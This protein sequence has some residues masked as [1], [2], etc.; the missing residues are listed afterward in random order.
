MQNQLSLFDENVRILENQEIRTHKQ[1]NNNVAYDVGV[2]IGGARKDQAALRK[3]FEENRDL[4]NLSLL[5][6]VSPV[7]AS[8]VVTRKEL[9]KDFSLSIE[10]EKGTSPQAAKIKDLVI[11][12]IQSIPSDS[13]ESREEFVKAALNYQML[14]ENI[15]TIDEFI[16]FIYEIR[17]KLTAD[18]MSMFNVKG[19]LRV[20]KE[21]LEKTPAPSALHRQYTKELK[22]YNAILDEGSIPDRVKLTALGPNFVKFFLSAKS[23]NTSLRN[24]KRDIQ[25]WDHLTIKSRKK[26]T[27]N[28]PLWERELPITPVI[29]AGYAYKIN[30]PT[31]LMELFSFRGVE[32]GHYM[33]D[34]R[35]ADHINNCASAFMD[36]SNVLNMNHNFSISLNGT[37]SMAF[38]SRGRGKA[39]GHYEP[40]AKVINL[41]KNRGLLG[42]A[43]HEWFHALDNW[44]F[45]MSHNYKNGQIGFMTDLEKYGSY[46]LSNAVVYEFKE[47]MKTITE[48]NSISEV[49]VMRMKRKPPITERVLAR[50]AY[51][52]CD[53]DLLQTMH[54]IHDALREHIDMA[55]Y[56]GE[57]VE[58]VKAKN[59]RTLRKL[60]S[61]VA[62]L[63]ESRTGKFVDT[64]PCP[65]N[66]SSYMQAALKLDKGNRG[67]YWSSNRELAARAFEAFLED[68]LQQAD[69][70]NDYLV[71][72]TNNPI[73][74]P[75]GE[76]REKINRKFEQ[77]FETFTKIHLI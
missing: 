30:K 48:G 67:K 21:R 43:A 57:Q 12:R 26:G 61:F 69:I 38:G 55:A 53:G 1:H 29:T 54:Y 49:P 72:K 28:Q 45:D 39:L 19:H 9:F 77:L 27:K 23:A 46:N 44:I 3:S 73:A 33:D 6:E 32:F 42:V 37:L 15:S 10:K 20:I 17:I 24:I 51:N 2:K 31:E 70:V 36:L 60:A 35:G 4:N 14:V 56:Y 41:T 25:S 5:E 76:E 47:L 71:Y 8:L 63:H 75:E 50:R 22:Y 65:T 64:V 40:I 62:E 18:C 66:T 52:E 58:K 16:E 74:F 34:N 7:E 11:K 68:K 13:K 59:D